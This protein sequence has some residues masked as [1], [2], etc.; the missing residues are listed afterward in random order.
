MLSF[1]HLTVG[2]P[3]AIY[4][5]TYNV[6]VCDAFTRDFLTREGVAVGPDE[7]TPEGLHD[8]GNACA[9]LGAIGMGVRG[10]AS[11]HPSPL[12]VSFLSTS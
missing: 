5:R 9:L 8:E 10:R 1:T 2:A 4:G 6:T 11:P 7:H 12:F 3:V